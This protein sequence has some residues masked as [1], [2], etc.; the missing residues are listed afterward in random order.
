MKFSSTDVRRN[1]WWRGRF[2]TSTNVASL[3]L[4][5]PFFSFEIPRQ[6]FGDFSFNTFVETVPVIYRQEL[7]GELIAYTASGEQTSIPVDLR[8]R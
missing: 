1:T 2:I 7:H 8:F 5:L 3:V 4:S 6:T